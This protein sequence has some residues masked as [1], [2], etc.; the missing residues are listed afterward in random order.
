MQ[1]IQIRAVRTFVQQLLYASC[2]M[3]DG[4]KWLP[5]WYLCLYRERVRGQSFSFDK[6]GFSSLMRMNRS[7]MVRR[8]VDAYI[9]NFKKCY[10][11]SYIY[12]LA[13]CSK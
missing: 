8:A 11:I 7:W 12:N 4:Y 9:S 13:I 5:C 3:E 10:I 1:L 6:A 2:L